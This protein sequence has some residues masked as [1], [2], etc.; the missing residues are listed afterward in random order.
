[1]VLFLLM[2]VRT[3]LKSDPTGLELLSTALEEGKSTSS[4]REPVALE[5]KLTSSERESTEG[6]WRCSCGQNFPN[7]NSLG[8][9]IGRKKN[10]ADHK[11]LGLGPPFK[12]LFEAKVLIAQRRKEYNQ[13]RPRSSLHYMPPAPEARMVVTLTL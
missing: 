1:M 12:T 8:G 3:D 5:N 6:V 9:H 11:S 7:M 2:A 4:E 10:K 13:V